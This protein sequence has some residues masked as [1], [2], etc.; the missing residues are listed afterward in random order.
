M[1]IK[2]LIAH[3]GINVTIARIKEKY[4]VN[5]PISGQYFFLIVLKLNQMIAHDA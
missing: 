1:P 3:V 5:Q 4:T 2:V